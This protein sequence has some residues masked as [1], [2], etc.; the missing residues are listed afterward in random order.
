MINPDYVKIAEEEIDSW[1]EWKKN[2]GN[3]DPAYSRIM[4]GLKTDSD[5]RSD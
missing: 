1:P 3:C 4:K 2:C 5:N